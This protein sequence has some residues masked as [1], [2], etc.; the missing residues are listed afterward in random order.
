M[1]LMLEWETRSGPDEPMPKAEIETRSAT[2]TDV[3]FPE[4]II[5]L[6]VVPYEEIAVVEYHGRLIEESFAR[7]AFG[8]GIEARASRFLVNLEHDVNH[9]VG[10]AQA[11]H[12]DRPE[13]LVAEIRI[14]RGPEGDQVLDDANDLMI[15]A[16]A[17]F[18]ALPEHQHWETRSRRKIMR[19][20]LGHIGLT[21][22]PAY[23]GA[24]I[25]AVRSSTL[26]PP[27]PD[28]VPGVPAVVRSLTPNLDSIYAA[29]LEASYSP[30]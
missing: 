10:R 24:G 18:A 3:R 12:P 14:R 2:V 22:T 21:W 16:S 1:T 5:D 17:G 15:G 13:G 27:P 23:E 26:P 9:V 28:A 25:L 29:R 19:A 11:I 20:F 4:R 8:K 6:I 30:H 7:G